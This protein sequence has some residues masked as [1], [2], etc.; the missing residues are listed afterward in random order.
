MNFHCS[1]CR[2]HILSFLMAKE[3]LA[4]VLNYQS[5][6][7][8]SALSVD[9]PEFPS[10]CPLHHDLKY[11]R[12]MMNMISFTLT[13]SSYLNNRLI[14]SGIILGSHCFALPKSLVHFVSHNSK[15]R[16]LQHRL[17]RI[18]DFRFKVPFV[19]I[20]PYILSLSIRF[21]NSS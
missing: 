2:H 12:N 7:L 21:I 19:I 20:R 11:I 18:W 14:L 4:V 13:T 17:P 15:R 3:F 1:P 8:S 10:T 6:S 9:N 5:S 16:S